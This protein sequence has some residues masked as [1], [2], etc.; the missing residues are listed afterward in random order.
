MKFS[1]HEWFALMYTPSK[2]RGQIRLFRLASASHVPSYIAVTVSR[3]NTLVADMTLECDEKNSDMSNVFKFA[4]LE[5]DGRTDIPRQP[6]SCRLP[7]QDNK[8]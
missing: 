2:F 3:Q 6:G 5:F 7:S 1:R 4:R 8:R